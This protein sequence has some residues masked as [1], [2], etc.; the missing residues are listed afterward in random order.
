MLAAIGGKE[1]RKGIRP[2]G[3]VIFQRGTDC[4]AYGAFRRFRCGKKRRGLREMRGEFLSQQGK[5]GTG[6]AAIA[7][8]K[9][10]KI[11]QYFHYC[12]KIS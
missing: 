10:G 3:G 12:A 4:T 8:F 1:P 11:A 6:S 7:P 2:Q 9:Y 5:L